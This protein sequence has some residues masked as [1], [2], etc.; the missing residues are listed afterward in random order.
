MVTQRLEV[1]LD[2]GTREELSYLAQEHDAPASEVVRRAIHRLYEDE[3][4]ERRRLAVERLAAMEVEEM[5]EPDELSRQLAST[6]DVD[7]P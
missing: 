3:M 7:L 4:R 1:R 2:E 5:P 6:Y